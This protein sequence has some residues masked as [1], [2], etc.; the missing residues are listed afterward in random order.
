MSGINGIG[1]NISTTAVIA[2]T[3]PETA[4]TAVKAKTETPSNPPYIVEL[5]AAA[6]AKSM[7]LQG[8][9]SKQIS[10]SMGLD[11]KT[12]DSYL[13]PKPAEPE[14]IPAPTKSSVNTESLIPAP[15][16]PSLM[17][18]DI[19]TNPTSVTSKALET[20][21]IPAVP[22]VLAPPASFSSQPS[23]NSA[24]SAVKALGI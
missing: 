16:K 7:E 23:V 15:A 17:T 11:V 22:A 21:G 19:T 8:L 1:N 24:P 14:F 4:S 2:P 13:N 12:V 5:T 6:I 10:S 3:K 18:Q 20:S 9:T